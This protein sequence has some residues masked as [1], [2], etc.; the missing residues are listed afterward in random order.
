LVSVAGVYR[1]T[2]TVAVAVDIADAPL[3][4][5]GPGGPTDTVRVIVNAAARLNGTAR[6][7]VGDARLR[8]RLTEAGSI[9]IDSI[10]AEAAY[11]DRRAH[12]SVSAQARG[13]NLLAAQADGPMQLSLSPAKVDL[14]D[15]PITGEVSIDSLYL[16]DLTGLI[17]GA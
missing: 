10:V 15:E 1:D 13:R 6:V 2:G 14:I 9:P 8:A 4:L 5:P 16:P 12:F 7:P 11:A 3:F 17:S